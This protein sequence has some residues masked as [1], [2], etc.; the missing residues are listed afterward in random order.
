MG[1]HIRQ[2]YDN[3][4]GDIYYP[5]EVKA[6]STNVDR[7]KMSLQLVLAALYQ[8]KNIQKW[9]NDLDWQP[10]PATYV[11]GLDDILMVPE[12]CPRYVL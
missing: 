9:K 8:P 11:A 5:W 3:F 12:D 4:L 6:R 1:A 10:I 2:T 7:T